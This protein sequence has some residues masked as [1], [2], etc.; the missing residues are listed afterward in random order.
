[1]HVATFIKFTRRDIF[2]AV[3]RI[4]L[5][6]YIFFSFYSFP[7]AGPALWLSSDDAALWAVRP[8]RKKKKISGVS[9]AKTT[10]TT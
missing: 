7:N 2:T 10:A 1:M 8:F 5:Y 6:I 9:A 4:F 3:A